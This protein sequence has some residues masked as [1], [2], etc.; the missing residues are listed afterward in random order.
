MTTQHREWQLGDDGEIWEM[1]EQGR[2]VICRC[3]DLDEDAALIWAAPALLAAC[4]AMR[5]AWR[6]NVFTIA[7]DGQLDDAISQATGGKS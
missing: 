7:L 3:E 6:D 4:E 5:A 1:T 2:R